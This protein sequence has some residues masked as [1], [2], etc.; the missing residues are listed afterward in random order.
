[1][2]KLRSAVAA[3]ARLNWLLARRQVDLLHLHVGGG[4]SF[5]RHMGYLML[6]WLARTPVLLHWHVPGAAEAQDAGLAGGLQRRLARW[7][8]N[9]AARVL[10]LSPAWA[11]SVD[12]VVGPARCRPAHGRAAEPGGL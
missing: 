9:H 10:V 11:D 2:A 8:I 4:S 12:G 6:G 1:M 3:L 5:Y 7:A